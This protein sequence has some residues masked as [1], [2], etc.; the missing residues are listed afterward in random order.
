MVGCWRSWLCSS[1]C[2][3]SARRWP[4]RVSSRARTIPPFHDL[5]LE[6]R[7]LVTLGVV[8]NLV[9]A[10]GG[11]IGAV[12]LATVLSLIAPVGE[13]RIAEPTTGIMFDSLV[14]LPGL[15]AI[16]VVVV[17]LGIWPA[18]RAPP[19]RWTGMTSQVCFGPRPSWGN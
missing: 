2:S 9:L 4:A 11:A 7:Q 13:A 6:Q 17:A 12:A 3:S 15:F 1:V 19:A 16:V 14:L 8:R 18:L 10:I 5:G